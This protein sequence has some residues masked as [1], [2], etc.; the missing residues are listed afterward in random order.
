VR[1]FQIRAVRSRLPL[2]SKFPSGLK[3]NERIPA[4][5][6]RLITR[7]VWALRISALV[8]FPSRVAAANTSPF[9]ARALAR[10]PLPRSIALTCPVARSSKWTCVPL[11]TSNVF[12]L[13]DSAVMGE[14]V[15]KV[16][17]GFVRCGSQ[18]ATWPPSV[19]VAKK[20]P[21]GL[22]AAVARRGM[23]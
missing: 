21:S 20:R 10:T 6:R 11:A 8:D 14:S 16:C 9:G 23:L 22:Q 17:T 19:P 4:S 3:A 1:A 7:P 5:G 15:A 2:A 12:E 13:K 18:T